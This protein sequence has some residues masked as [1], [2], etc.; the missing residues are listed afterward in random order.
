MTTLMNDPFRPTLRRA[1]GAPREQDACRPT[2][3]DLVRLNPH[4]F[5]EG[6]RQMAGR[7]PSSSR[8]CNARC[9]DA[10]AHIAA[11]AMPVAGHFDASCVPGRAPPRFRAAPWWPSATPRQRA[12]QPE[13]LK[14]III[15]GACRSVVAPPRTRPR[16]PRV[17][18]GLPLLEPALA[19]QRLAVRASAVDPRSQTAGPAPRNKT[20]TGHKTPSVSGRVR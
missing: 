14:V 3:L 18:R 19:A 11:R 20:Q 16:D 13:C 8:R 5:S 7:P 9:E 10:P 6:V 15:A 1:F 17:K 4:R 12:T 2:A